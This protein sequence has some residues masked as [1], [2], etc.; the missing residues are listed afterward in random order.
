MRGP[1]E[2]TLWLEQDPRAASE[3]TGP[4]GWPERTWTWLPPQ[5]GCTRWLGPGRARR[6]PE[7]QP[8]HATLTCGTGANGQVW[9]RLAT[10]VRLVTQHQLANTLHV[11]RPSRAPGASRPRSRLVTHEGCSPPSGRS[12][13][14]GSCEPGTMDEDPPKGPAFNCRHP[15]VL[16]MLEFGEGAP[17]AIRDDW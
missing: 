4:C 7:Q 17:M 15:G 14:F 11:W 2:E 13:C 1:L 16:S 12:T 3:R 8:G 10:P 6:G 5:P 9:H